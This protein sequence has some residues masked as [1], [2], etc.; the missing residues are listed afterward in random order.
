MFKQI[1]ENRRKRA[2]EQERQRIAVEQEEERLKK[3]RARI[4]QQYEEEQRRQKEAQVKELVTLGESSSSF[5]L[6]FHAASL[7]L[8]TF[9]TGTTPKRSDGST[10]S[11][12][13]T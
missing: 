1:E 4:L 7:Y 10:K 9:I 2:E 3:E 5:L 12:C 11:L 13:S 6:V 8:F